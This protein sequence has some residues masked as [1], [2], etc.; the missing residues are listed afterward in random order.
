MKV[1][2]EAAVIDASNH[3]NIM[4]G[5]EQS[6]K[7]IVNSENLH[8][9]KD[10]EAEKSSND[11]MNMEHVS[12]L[13]SNVEKVTEKSMPE[14][15]DS[16]SGENLFDLLELKEMKDD[17]KSSEED[18]H[19]EVKDVSK[20]GIVTETIPVRDEN[21]ITE[22]IPTNIVME[23]TPS[24][25]T[26]HHVPSN[27]HAPTAEPENVEDYDANNDLLSPNEEKDSHKSVLKSSHFGND[28]PEK[29]ILFKHNDTRVS[30]NEEL[31]DIF[32]DDKKVASEHISSTTAKSEEP[33][34]ITHE[35]KTT[36]TEHSV[37]IFDKSAEIEKHKENK[38]PSIFEDSAEPSEHSSEE[39]VVAKKHEKKIYKNKLF[40]KESEEGI[41]HRKLDR[42]GLALDINKEDKEKETTQVPMTTEVPALADSGEGVIDV[43]LKSLDMDADKTTE[44]NEETT[45]EMKQME[46]S[47]T[48]TSVEKE[49]VMEEQIE[50][51]SPQKKENM[52]E[53][54][55][56]VEEDPKTEIP[57]VTTT[58][59]VLDKIMNELKE[60]PSTDVVTE[61]MDNGADNNEPEDLTKKDEEHIETTSM[62]ID[63]KDDKVSDMENQA[64]T[65]EIITESAMITENMKE[66]IKEAMEKSNDEK[67]DKVTE[68]NEDSVE[69][70]TEVSETEEQKTEK[71]MEEIKIEEVKKEKEEVSTSSPVPQTTTPIPPFRDPAPVFEEPAPPQPSSTQDPMLAGF[72]KCTAGN[73]SLYSK[74]LIQ[75][76]SHTYRVINIA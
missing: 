44:T 34:D 40:E 59:V 50:I 9:M 64:S 24:P 53:T 17:I 37:N 69:K 56:L 18:K 45:T 51:L 43:R 54:K 21:L 61:R 72:S 22:T 48:N 68:K 5:M 27:E 3:S 4:E 33:S 11:S 15:T 71:V 66:A 58:E 73:K 16:K 2:L 30:D 74:L 8:F 13:E 52:T 7:D 49:N 20:S 39:E 70:T 36:T 26:T 67:M 6:H 14:D 38:T 46:N 12:I 41:E 63:M 19:D 28:Q 29:I 47:S 1:D 35:T 31:N 76:I 62:K 55:E 75:L 10:L 57:V 60:V 32:L 25:S 42:L 23:S 65:E